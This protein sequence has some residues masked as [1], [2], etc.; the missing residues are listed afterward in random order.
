[1]DFVTSY[2]LPS[3]T[4]RTSPVLATGCLLSSEFAV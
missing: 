4:S 3:G 2:L 1:V